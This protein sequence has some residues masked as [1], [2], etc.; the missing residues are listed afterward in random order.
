MPNLT[1][2]SWQLW[3]ILLGAL[4]V[5]AAVVGGG[6]KFFGAELPGINSV[7]RQIILSVFGIVLIATSLV[8]GRG[9]NTTTK[10]PPASRQIALNFT[11]TNFL[12]HPAG[13]AVDNNGTVYVADHDHNRVMRLAAGSDTPTQMLQFTGLNWPSG[14]AVDTAGSVYVADSSNNRVL[15]LAAGSTTPA[16]LLTGL[17]GPLAVA[18][19][20]S[21][22]VYVADTGNSQVL[23]LAARSTTPTTLPFTGLITPAGVAVDSAGSVYVTDLVAL[24]VYKLSNQAPRQQIELFSYAGLGGPKGVAVD[25]SLNVYVTDASNRVLKLAADS[26]T[27]AKL[28]FTNLDGPTGVAVDNSNGNVYVADWGNGLLLKLS[29]K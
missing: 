27:P 17:N 6:V 18:V 25:S 12:L 21:L 9:P 3:L 8:W 16:P 14:V 20:A 23:E 10:M 1:L 5:V 19:D 22:N 13:V 2:Q 29:P 7:R 15:K 26:S 28:D 24:R 11:G 4:C